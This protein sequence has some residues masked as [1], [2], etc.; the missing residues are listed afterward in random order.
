MYVTISDLSLPAY[1]Q[2]LPFTNYIHLISLPKF[3]LPLIGTFTW[4]TPPGPYRATCRGRELNYGSHTYFFD[5]TK[6]WRASPVAGSAQC[7][8]HLQDKTNMKDDTHRPTHPSI[9]TKRIWKDDYDSQMIFRDLVGLKLPDFCFTG[10]EKP[11]KKTSPRKLVPTGNQTRARWWQA[12]MLQPAPQRW[13]K[14]RMQSR[15][16]T[17]FWQ[18]GKFQ[19]SVKLSPSVPSVEL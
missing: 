18:Y 12:R 8:N 19:N 5:H 2:I 17:K 4:P 13:T 14:S 15:K 9:L 7:R 10:E 6:T 3:N 16:I 11:R 1:I